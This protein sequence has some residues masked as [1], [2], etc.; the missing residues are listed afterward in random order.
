MDASIQQVN[1]IQCLHWKFQKSKSFNQKHFNKSL[2]IKLREIFNCNS[3]S[4][5]F[6]FMLIKTEDW[7]QMIN[8]IVKNLKIVMSVF[9]CDLSLWWFC[10]ILGW[11]IWYVLL[12]TKSIN[13][14]AKS[15]PRFN[16]IKLSL[17]NLYQAIR[18]KISSHDP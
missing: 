2:R 4:D 17:K 13:Y 10:D 7:A 15:F 18:R 6:L 3:K 5:I 16:R 12:Y 1:G 9:F 14:D 11:T 8:E